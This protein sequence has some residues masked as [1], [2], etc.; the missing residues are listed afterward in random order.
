LVEPARTSGLP[1]AAKRARQILREIFVALGGLAEEQAAKRITPLPGDFRHAA[2]GTLIEVDQS[3]HFTSY[4]LTSLALYPADALVGFDVQE[5][6]RLCR[7]WAPRSDRY[8]AA[9]AAVGFGGGGRQRQR[10]YHETL[11]DLVAPEMGRPPVIRVPAADR[12]G[13]AS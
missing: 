7:E 12:N 13:E 1:A 8:W 2:T 10:A 11:R 4:R 5:Y 3:Q 6:Q 9:K